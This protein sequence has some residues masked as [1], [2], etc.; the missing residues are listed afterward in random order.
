MH[1]PMV[2]L[3]QVQFQFQWL[4]R[5]KVSINVYKDSW[6]TN[7]LLLALLDHINMDAIYLNMHYQFQN[8]GYSIAGLLFLY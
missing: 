1:V 4:G 5:S 8:M 3:L 6:I 7:I 2:I